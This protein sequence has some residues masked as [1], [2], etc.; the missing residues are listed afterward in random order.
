[1]NKILKSCE[2]VS[3]YVP[4][5]LLQLFNIFSF[6]LLP[7]IF[8]YSLPFYLF[9]LILFFFEVVPLIFLFLFMDHLNHAYYYYYYYVPLL[10]QFS[11]TCP[12]FPK[13]ICHIPKC[14]LIIIF[15]LCFL[16]FRVFR[17]LSPSYSSSS[18]LSP[19]I[20]SLFSS[21]FFTVLFWLFSLLLFSDFLSIRFSIICKM[22]IHQ[23]K[24]SRD[25]SF[26]VCII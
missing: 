2:D 5:L 13:K 14:Y 25:L 12:Y 1:M 8:H 3:Y 18:F 23:Y 4:Y 24:P 6:S 22:G 21:F 9:F 7:F 17:H 20:S 19:I 10:I 16:F 26:I 11:E 15:I